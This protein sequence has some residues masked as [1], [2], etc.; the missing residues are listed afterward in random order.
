MIIKRCDIS[1]LNALSEFYNEVVD[2]LVKTVNYP[3][4]MPGVY[5]CEETIKQSVLKGEQ[6][7]LFNGDQIVG[8]FVFNEDP[9]G[10]YG[11]GNWSARLNEGEYAVIH[12]LA[13]HFSSYG[14]G[15][16]KLM[17]EY[18]LQLAKEKGY[19]AVRLD[20][21]PDNYPAVRLYESLGFTFA[22]E[23]DLHR[24]FK[25]IPTFLLYEYNF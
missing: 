1:N 24:G 11:V 18:C 7:A 2:Y 13:T 19:K 10:D 12:T 14:K 17:V 6:F 4:W 9:A 3:K 22:G 5:P 15:V 21:V 8:A 20:V 16:A 23:K 25:D